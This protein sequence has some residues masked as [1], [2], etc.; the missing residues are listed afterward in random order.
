MTM[1][2]HRLWLLA[3]PAVLALAGCAGDLLPVKE[4][5]LQQVQQLPAFAEI[6]LPDA[7]FATAVLTTVRTGPNGAATDVARAGAATSAAYAGAAKA[8]TG[9]AT[10]PGPVVSGPVSGT[11]F[12]FKKTAD[13]A[14]SWATTTATGMPYLFAQ[15]LGQASAAGTASWRARVQM[16]PSGSNLY[17]QFMLPEAH[18]DGFDEVQGPSQWQSRLRVEVQMNGH[19]VWADEATRVSLLETPPE[20]GGENCGNNGPK[21]PFLTSFGRDLG[22]DAT[23]NHPSPAQKVTLNLG[24]FPAGQW[25]EVAMIVRTDAQV[26]RPCCPHDGNNKPELFCTRATSVVSW[27]GSSQPVRFWA[28]PNL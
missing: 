12:D 5:S 11:I 16:P 8:G 25:V 3:G 7:N 22:F 18:L 15:A 9:A 17:V 24:A 4:L 26:L 19:P 23:P 14:Q 1:P 2:L 13:S 10:P 28:G 27:D 6:G 20:G 21:G